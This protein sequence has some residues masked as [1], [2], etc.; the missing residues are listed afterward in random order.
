MIPK[1]I[2]EIKKEDI[3]MLIEN[4]IPEGKTI[5]YKQKLSI[6]S[7]ED[8]KEF[9]KDVSSFANAEGGDIIYGLTEENRFPKEI[10][11]IEIENLDKTLLKLLNMIK[12]GIEPTLIPQPE[13]NALEIE[14]NKFILVLRVYKSF[15]APHRISFERNHKFWLR[16]DGGNSEMSV[17]ELRNAFNFSQAI[18]EK[19]QN[20]M[21]N[22]LQKIITK[23]TPVPLVER[24]STGTMDYKGKLLIHIIPLQSF[25]LKEQI[26]INKNWEIIKDQLDTI[27]HNFIDSMVMLSRSDRTSKNLTPIINLDGLL[28]Y[29]TDSALNPYSYT[30]LYR[31]GIIESVYTGIVDRYNSINA[32][33]IW[34][35]TTDF[36]KR[37]LQFYKE[38]GSSQIFQISGPKY[39]F[40]SL[41]DIKDSEISSNKG[42]PKTESSFKDRILQLPEV[43]IDESNE[44]EPLKEILKPLFEILLNTFGWVSN[45]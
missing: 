25:A 13:F 29:S 27:H 30:Q 31:N 9:Y 12:S 39:I 35:S 16:E 19:V 23:E 44:N 37:T 45:Q 38:I 11:G 43:E 28:N 33:D 41:L 36:I 17:T 6:E 2:K 1:P 34:N 20:F 22:R 32:D 8:K 10:I 15:T 42:D 14:A 18:I 5:D 7:N 24:L 40:I 21:M 4:R 3:E 26:D